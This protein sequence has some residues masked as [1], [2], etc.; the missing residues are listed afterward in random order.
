MNEDIGDLARKLSDRTFVRHHMLKTAT[1]ICPR[2]EDNIDVFRVIQQFVDLVIFNEA[3]SRLSKY[4]K[5][6]ISMYSQKRVG[7]YTPKDLDAV[8]LLELTDIKKDFEGVLAH[9]RIHEEVPER[10]DR[11]TNSLK[12]IAI[13]VKSLRKDSQRVVSPYLGDPKF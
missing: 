5:A 12:I 8:D 6:I 7:F 10:R 11:I 1:V 2:N 9:I 13:L 4:I 3:K